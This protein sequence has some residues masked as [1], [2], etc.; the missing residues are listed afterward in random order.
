METEKEKTLKDF[1]RKYPFSILVAEDDTINQQLS[2][3]L[4]ERFG[5][6]AD[7]ASN[8]REAF[9]MAGK[10]NYDVILMDVQMPETDG[11]EATKMIR[12]SL[13][14]QP[15]IIALTAS[16]MAGD[17]EKCVSAGMNDYLCKPININELA[18]LFE[19]WDEAKKLAS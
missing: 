10:K 11:F 9:E 8:G 4:L 18:E 16:A 15:F 2:L 13:P 3:R 6:K 5:Y 17:K 12:T 19:R 7:L 1:F 14:V